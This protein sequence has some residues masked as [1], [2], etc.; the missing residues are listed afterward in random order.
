MEVPW[1]KVTPFIDVEQF[2]CPD[3]FLFQFVLLTEFCRAPL[4]GC[5][6][7]CIHYSSI[8]IRDEPKLCSCVQCN[9]VQFVYYFSGEFRVVA[10]RKGPVIVTVATL[11]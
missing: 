10:L 3:S 9:A 7:P 1:P 5:P 2:H 8:D 11:R 6:C 4:L